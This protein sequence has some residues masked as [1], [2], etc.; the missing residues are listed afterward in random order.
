MTGEWWLSSEQLCY[1]EITYTVFA[2][3]QVRA[4][5]GPLPGTPCSAR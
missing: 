4:G 5:I 3:A 1:E 2:I